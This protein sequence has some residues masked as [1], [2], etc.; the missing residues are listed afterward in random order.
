MREPLTE[1]SKA[2]LR[3]PHRAWPKGYDEWAETLA[4]IEDEAIDSTELRS[5][6]SDIPAGQPCPICGPEGHGRHEDDSY[7]SCVVC[8]SY[9]PHSDMAYERVPFPCAV[10][11]LEAQS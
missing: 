2:L 3:R 10:A 4:I 1:A 8:M 7:G 11:I 5:P 6:E 9:V